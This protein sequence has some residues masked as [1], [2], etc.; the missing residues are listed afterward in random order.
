MRRFIISTLVLIGTLLLAYFM[1]GGNP[2]DLI[3]P[4]PLIIVVCMPICAVL[5]VWSFKDWG[6]AWKDAFMAGFVDSATSTAASSARLWDFYERACY[7]AGVVAFILGLTIVGKNVDLLARL[8][9]SLAVDCVT[10]ILAILFAMV[11]RI[12]RARVEKNAT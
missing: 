7:I 8:G 4:S 11:A 2:L 9:P 3:L 6:R 5:A 1:E 12:L 10:P